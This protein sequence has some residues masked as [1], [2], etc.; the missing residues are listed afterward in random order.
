MPSGG[1][2]GQLSP[3][4]ILLGMLCAID[5]GRPAHLVAGWAALAELDVSDQLRLGV[6]TSARG[7]LQRATYRQF[8]STHQVMIRAIDPQPVPSFK[9]VPDA[10]RAQHLA[11]ARAQLDADQAGVRLAG[12][13]DA[14]VE[15]SV[16]DAYKFAT[17]SLAI[18]WSDHETWSRPR[19]KDDPVPAND[20][21]ASWGHAKRNAPGAID[22]LFFGYYAQVATMVNDEGK[23]A[24][25]E[26]IR[27]VAFAPP[28][29]DPAALMASTVVRAYDE[30]VPAG[31]V[32]CDCG[33]SNRHPDT[34]AARL[35]RAGARLVMD[36]HPADRGP[37]GTHQ[38]AVIAN[39]NL[40]CPCT[41]R[42][43]LE[44]GPLGRQ[45]NED[46]VIV[47]DARSAELARYKLGRICAEDQDGAH[48]V[49]C[50]ALLGKVRCALRP[51]SMASD[52]SHPE[53]LDAPEHPPKC[54]VQQTITVGGQIAAKAAQRHDYPSRA[55]RLSYRRRTA[56]ERTFAWLKDPAT[57]AMRRGWSRLMGLAKNSLLFALAAVVRNVRAV[58]SFERRRAEEARR[59]SLGS[60][61]RRRR[62]RVAT[63]TEPLD[64]ALEPIDSG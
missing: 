19:P 24:V 52:F 41:P 45:S 18:D 53:V 33:Y 63:A 28:S 2:P 51:T 7:Q 11:D 17:S 6:A 44:L 15:A 27:R 21:D 54:C 59:A 14:L 57:L 46:T 35:R 30:G 55:H 38:G 22:H 64:P 43:L 16:P 40:Y 32:L 23:D 48:R 4:A 20:P 29:Q 25:P 31:D 10:G 61:P 26:L 9:G 56:S 36:L 62:R 58:E 34:F 42:P 3:K 37:K 1:R 8:S 5:R 60:S 39:G 12:V 47:H 50:P 13:L 49:M